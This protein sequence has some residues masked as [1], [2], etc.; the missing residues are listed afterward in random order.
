MYFK[1]AARTCR[2]A[3]RGQPPTLA[4]LQKRWHKARIPLGDDWP[5]RNLRAKAA[6]DL[7]SAQQARGLL[8]HTLESTDTYRRGRIGEFAQPVNRRIAGKR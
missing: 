5:I 8:G 2:I 7:S 1:C 4:A 6:S 3:Q